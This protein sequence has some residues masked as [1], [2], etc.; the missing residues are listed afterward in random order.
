MLRVIVLQVSL[1]STRFLRKHA[2][3]IRKHKFLM[4]TD[5]LCLTESQ[6][7]ANDD[8]SAVCKEFT[9]FAIDFKLCGERFENH[10]FC[11]DKGINLV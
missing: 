1:L 7:C 5:I 8:T 11:I 4:K 3:N 6:I 2:E 9:T 10:A